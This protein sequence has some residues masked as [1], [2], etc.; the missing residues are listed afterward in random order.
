MGSAFIKQ[1]LARAN[2]RGYFFRVLY[3]KGIFD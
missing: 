1:I 3:S 2:L